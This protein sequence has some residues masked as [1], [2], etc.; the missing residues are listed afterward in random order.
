MATTTAPAS[1]LAGSVDVTVGVFWTVD[2]F[3]SMACT[4]PHPFD[5]QCR[6]GDRVLKAVFKVLHEGPQR[7]A[8]WRLGQLSRW[9][10]RG[11]ELQAQEDELKSNTDP[12]V[13]ACLKDKKLLLLR[14]MLKVAGH[15]ESDKL[16]GDLLV[17]MPILGDLAD[18]GV[19]PKKE[20]EADLSLCELLASAAWAQKAILQDVRSSGDEDLDNE[21]WIGT[22]QEVARGWA[23]GPL[24]PEE[25]TAKYG[26]GWIAAKRFGLRQRSGMRMIDDF[27]AYHHN[28]CTSSHER[29]DVGG[30]DEVASLCKAWL[31]MKRGGA[32]CA[33]MDDGEVWEGDVSDEFDRGL[34]VDL[35]GRCFDLEK[36]FKQIPVKKA[37]AQFAIICVWD[38]HTE[39]PKFFEAKVLPFGVKASVH[40]FNRVGRALAVVLTSLFAIPCNHYFDDYPIV[41]CKQ[42]CENAGEVAMKVFELLRWVV[43][44]EGDKAEDFSDTLKTLGVEFHLR[45]AARGEILVENRRDRI[46]DISSEIRQVLAT[47]ILRPAHAASLRGKLLFAQGQTFGRCGLASLRILGGWAGAGCRPSWKRVEA[48]LRFWLAYFATA[49]PRSLTCSDQRP[50]VIFTDG[51]CEGESYDVVTVGGVIYDPITGTPECFGLRVPEHT[52]KSWKAEG[53]EQ[54][55]GQAELL[56]VY[57]AKCTWSS[58]VRGRRVLHFVDNDS[59]KFALIKGTS[60]REDSARILDAFWQLEVQLGTYSWFDRVRSESNP[61]DAPWRLEFSSL[62]AGI[63]R[64]AACWDQASVVSAR[65]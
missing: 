30:V 6:P 19:F 48:A 61:A 11:K 41:T 9:T 5:L 54:V 45:N 23:A 2:E 12:E 53:K 55:I 62:R 27:S 36:A 49:I 35:R 56:P 24:S 20:A 25:L 34:G 51:A 44:K 65:W 7:V 39:T 59:A 60:A 26:K 38:P 14:D 16:A 21:V 43:K 22:L 33:T 13:A 8:E 57:I 32:V 15:A 1:A 28:S 31:Q 50:V 29:I 46:E 63:V 18:T 42:D 17:G 58:R 3:Q 64:V 47:G 4:V 37:H 40:S 52:V 10:R